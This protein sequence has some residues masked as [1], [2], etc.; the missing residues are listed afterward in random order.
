MQNQVFREYLRQAQI[1]FNFSVFSFSLSFGISVIGSVL[2]L[3]G[4]VAE[5]VATTMSG[6]VSSSFCAQVA[7]DSSNKLKKLSDQTKTIDMLS[8]RHCELS[9]LPHNALIDSTTGSLRKQDS[10]NGL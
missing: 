10:Q 5:G 3:C 8:D 1:I 6:L 7:K 2:L 9:Y 4:Q